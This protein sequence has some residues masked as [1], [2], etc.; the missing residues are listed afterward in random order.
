MQSTKLIKS[1]IKQYEPN[2]LELFRKYNVFKIFDSLN[3]FDL[4]NENELINLITD[5]QDFKAKNKEI[6]D[7]S[8]KIKL[9]KYYVNK[10]G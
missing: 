8:L 6:D 4:N 2:N 1:K 9:H 7:S 10:F 5:F 3:D